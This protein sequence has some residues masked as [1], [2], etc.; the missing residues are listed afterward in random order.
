MNSI[1]CIMAVTVAVAQAEFETYS[2]FREAHINQ[3]QQGIGS[4]SLQGVK[5]NG[6]LDNQ[7]LDLNGDRIIVE[8]SSGST[9]QTSQVFQWVLM[10]QYG[11]LVGTDNWVCRY[12]FSQ[13]GPDC[14]P[15]D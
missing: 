6:P 11:E 3:L 2:D 15:E 8:C 7:A 12:G 5:V 1:K 10:H 4:W 9:G 13:V 14:T